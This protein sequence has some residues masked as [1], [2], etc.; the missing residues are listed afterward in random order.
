MRSIFF[1]LLLLVLLR[2]VQAQDPANPLAALAPLVGGTWVAQ[3][4]WENNG[5]IRQE[6]R[7]RW[8]LNQKTLKVETYGIVDPE[9]PPCSQTETRPFDF[10]I[11][12]WDVE[13]KN[14]P[15]GSE[16]WTENKTWTR[17]RVR[18]DLSG[19]ALIEESIDKIGSEWCLGR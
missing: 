17:T 12:E 6:I 10:W 11:G 3:G 13:A 19:C 5:P 2:P 16:Q 14:R 9:G 8:G 15:P 4:T 7:D 1:P 18:S